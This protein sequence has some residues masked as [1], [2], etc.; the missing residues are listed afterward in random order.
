MQ[1]LFEANTNPAPAK[2]DF[3]SLTAVLRGLPASYKTGALPS[4]W[5][6]LYG[7]SLD[8]DENW[9]DVAASV[10]AYI[11]LKH[12]VNQMLAAAMLMYTRYAKPFGNV[13]APGSKP[14]VGHYIFFT[15][16]SV[17]AGWKAWLAGL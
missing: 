11:E 2:Y 6:Q 7:S 15:S 1:D 13:M 3:S 5:Q 16:A 8:T 4:S 17:K 9:N 10:Y 14:G 12:G